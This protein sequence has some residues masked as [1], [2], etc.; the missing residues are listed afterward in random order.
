MALTRIQN[1]NLK[2]IFVHTG[3][4]VKNT[5]KSGPVIMLN[6]PLCSY[7][8]F[9]AKLAARMGTVKLVAALVSAGPV[10]PPSPAGCWG[11]AALSVGPVQLQ[12]EREDNVQAHQLLAHQAHLHL[13]RTTPTNKVQMQKAYHFFWLTKKNRT[14]YLNSLMLF[15]L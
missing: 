7:L 2:K 13:F 11:G 8:S 3:S 5:V 6:L 15:L 4:E 12:G 1:K 14:S 10:V 9:N